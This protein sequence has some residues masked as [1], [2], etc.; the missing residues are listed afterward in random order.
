MLDLNKAMIEPKLRKSDNIED[1]IN[2]M[3]ELVN[4]HFS[5]QKQSRKQFKMA[6]KLG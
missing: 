2:T 1:L 5:K 3:S 6:N 4:V